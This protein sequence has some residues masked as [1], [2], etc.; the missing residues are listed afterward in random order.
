[1][2]GAEGRFWQPAEPRSGEVGVG[3]RS[4]DFPASIKSPGRV[5]GEAVLKAQGS[6]LERAPMQKQEVGPQ[7]TLASWHPLRAKG[8]VGMQD[9]QECARPHPC[10]QGGVET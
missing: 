8:R 10:Q 9:L 3:E 5:P 7:W 1:M 4:F 2:F 6:Q